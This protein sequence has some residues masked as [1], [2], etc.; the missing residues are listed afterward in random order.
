MADEQAAE[1]AD[2][3]GHVHGAEAENASDEHEA[4]IHRILSRT[5]HQ[6]ALRLRGKDPALEAAEQQAQ[7]GGGLAVVKEDADP[8]AGQAAATT[9]PEATAEASAGS[10]PAQPDPSSP[11]VP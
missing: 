10:T 7:Q 5:F 11:G 9:G 6:F 4:R 3:M 8:T 2:Q 1:A